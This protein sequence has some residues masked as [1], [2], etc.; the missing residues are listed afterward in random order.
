MSSNYSCCGLTGKQNQEEIIGKEN[1]RELVG[2]GRNVKR[3]SHMN[4][5]MR[6]IDT[7]NT[8]EGVKLLPEG[9]VPL[10]PG[11]HSCRWCRPLCRN[12]TDW[13]KCSNLSLWFPGCP[14][15]LQWLLLS[16]VKQK[17]IEYCGQILHKVCLYYHFNT[18]SGF[19]LYTVLH[20]S[21]EENCISKD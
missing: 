13:G 18:F 9:T 6:I 21:C 14:S 11:S 19:H 2:R 8:T 12:R 7:H 4:A 15:A 5:G 1:K 17:Q 10:S 20:F 16:T 3:R